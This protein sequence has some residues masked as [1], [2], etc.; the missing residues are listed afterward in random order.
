MSRK[1]STKAGVA[2]LLGLIVVLASNPVLATLSLIETGPN[3]FS[4]ASDPQGRAR[5][6]TSQA[7]PYVYEEILLEARLDAHGPSYTLLLLRRSDGRLLA[8]GQDLRKWRLRLPLAPTLRHLEHDYYLLDELPGLRY[9]VDESTLTLEMQ[10]SPGLFDQTDLGRE[11][12]FRQAVPAPPG[13]FLNY[14][15]HASRTDGND[16]S[17]G[18]FELGLFRGAGVGTSTFQYKDS[19]QGSGMIRLETTWT[20]DMPDRRASLRFGDAIGT[21]GSWGRAPRFGGVQ[22]ATNFATQPNFVVFP[23][24]TIAGEA[25]LPSTLDLYVNGVLRFRDEVPSGPFSLSELPIVTGQGEVQLVIRDLLG[26]EQ[27]ITQGF[28]A[29]PSILKQGLQDFSYEL[30]KVREDFGIASNHYGRWIAAGTHRWGLS[31]QFTVELRGEMLAG[32][33]ALGASGALLWRGLGI[34]S[35]ATALSDSDLGSGALVGL[36]FQRSTRR[37]SFGFNTQVTNGHFSQAGL[38]VGEA[39]PRRQLQAY[40]SW[41]LREFGALGLNY[42]YGSGRGDET[43]ETLGAS[44]NV[45]VGRLGYLGISAIRFLGEEPQT[46]LGLTY[47][48]SLGRRRTGS[49]RISRDRNAKQLLLRA[50]Q[51]LPVGDGYGYRVLV[52]ALD[53]DR[54]ELGVSA[55]TAY[56][57]YHFDGARNDGH[58]SFQANAAGGLVMLGGELHASRYL[59]DS[60]AVVKVGEYEG[61]RVYADNHLVASTGAGGTALLPRLRAYQEN[62]IRIEVADLPLGAQ[63]NQVK[64]EAVPYFRSGLV[65]EFPVK[66]IRGVTLTAIMEDGMPVPPGST[67]TRLDDGSTT[68]V[69]LQGT[70]YLTGP[71]ASSMLRVSWPERSCEF[72]VAYEPSPDPLPDLGTYRCM[73][74]SP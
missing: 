15:L 38:P 70:I 8:R 1:R 24:P 3:I 60:F 74:V 45:S 68:V 69:G 56:G 17:S 26:R 41:P 25:A 14:D 43:V 58:N 30:G 22:W 2:L 51:S 13:G 40:M 16:H 64:L 73:E 36:G 63:V 72:T 7:E 67:V 31:E 10:A 11:H 19:T 20:R 33:R 23:L 35:I 5:D 37:M 66:D 29:S 21:A 61:V 46:I 54:L 62:P 50:Q 34:L 9:Q 32:Q 42:A 49:A 12:S 44:Y 55:R 59:Y 39:A 48:R 4:L 18:L 53:T 6:Q 71:G 47:S 28:Y 52:G 65:L 27:L 57:T